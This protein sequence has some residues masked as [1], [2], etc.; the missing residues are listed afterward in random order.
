[1]LLELGAVLLGL[2]LLA[3]L[4]H[5]HG[6]SA[7]PAYLLAGVVLG[8]ISDDPLTFSADVVHTAA[9]VGLVLLLFTLGLEYTGRELAD[10]MRTSR[11]SAALDAALNFPPGLLAGLLLGW[12]LEAAILLGGITYISSSGIVAKLIA[13]LGRTNERET[14]AVISILVMEDIAMAVY[15]PVVAVLLAAGGLASGLGLLALALAA[16][17]VA[18]VVAMRFGERLAAAIHVRSEEVLLLTLLGFAL[19]MA[20]AAE[21]A[22][23]S[24]AVG[25]FL[26]GITLSGPVADRGR[27]V[28]APV[29][30]VLA[31]SFFVLF[32]LGVDP[33]E[34]NAVLLAALTLAAL[35]SVTKAVT[36]WKAATLV[37]ADAGGRAR[38]GTV[39]MARGEFSIVIA[40]L[41]VAAGVNGDLASLAAVYV[42]T[43]AVGASVVTRWADGIGNR[44]ARL[45][46]K[47]LAGEAE[48]P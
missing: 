42:L 47:R 3:R 16:A 39:L 17:A 48:P 36:G 14:P 22:K 26:A 20:G 8:Q 15:L 1:M 21:A 10:A 7:V 30:D 6:V 40:G 37:G 27:V 38:A 19:L 13:D 45:H 33:P 12:S 32:G 41:G 35:T 23:L 18:L 2:A 44:I 29:R 31:A 34:L 11:R 24:A 43:T 46:G 5:R 28:I 9:E 4:A 25:A